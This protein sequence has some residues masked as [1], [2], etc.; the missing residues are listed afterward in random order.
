MIWLLSGLVG[1]ALVLVFFVIL[2]HLLVRQAP[3][4]PTAIELH[5]ARQDIRVAGIQTLGGI[6]LLGGLFFTY[7]TIQVTRDGQITERFT[8]AIDQLGSEQ[9]DVRLGGIYSLERIAKESETDHGPIMEVLTAYLRERAPWPPRTDFV[10]LGLQAPA[11]A[12][13][14]T[15]RVR[16]DVQAAVTVIGRRDVTK[17]TD[18]L[19]L[20]AVDLRHAD[21]SGANLSGANLFAADPSGADLS[22][23]DLSQADLSQADLS[24]ALLS[25]ANLSGA[26]LSEAN[27]SGAHLSQADLSKADLSGA[28][29]AGADLSGADLSRVNGLTQ[30]QIDSST[31]SSETKLPPG[32]KASPRKGPG[33]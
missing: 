23:A 11:D 14:D 27:L 6:L 25:H 16:T 5:K 21:I 12:A 15:I 17:D 8:R 7:Q 10:A 19:L 4:D 33:S 9:L 28:D 31:T 20:I 3:P 2:P 32:F 30:T 26:L 22:Q 24:A 18:R 1:L 29:L 13:I